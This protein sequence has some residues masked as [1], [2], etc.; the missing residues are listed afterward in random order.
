MPYNDKQNSSIKIG[1]FIFLLI[2]CSFAVFAGTEYHYGVNYTSVYSDDF[3]WSTSWASHNYNLSIDGGVSPTTLPNSPFNFA[4]VSGGT[5]AAGVNKS[6]AGTTYVSRLHIYDI[7]DSLIGNNYLSYDIYV[8][9]QTANGTDMDIVLVCGD[10]T[11]AIYNT[12]LITYLTSSNEIWARSSYSKF[13]TGAGDCRFSISRDVINNIELQWDLTSN[14]YSMYMNGINQ[15]NGLLGTPSANAC[16]QGF[17]LRF[18][19]GTN[20]KNFSGFIDNIRIATTLI[21][22]T[23]HDVNQPCANNLNCTTRYCNQGLCQFKLGNMACSNNGECQ[24]GLCSN[25]YC[26]SP[27]LSQNLGIF[28]DQF[29]GTDSTTSN[30][31]SV[32]VMILLAC[33]IGVTLGRLSPVIGALSGFSVFFIMG[34]LFAMMGWLSPWIIFGLILLLISFIVGA[35]VLSSRIS[36]GGGG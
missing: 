4:N 9:S 25:G 2:I 36:Q 19:G 22:S 21:N 8:S 29:F 16:V 33:V 28:K 11:P 14:S 32:I 26:T 23:T 18:D 17:D 7:F 31:I 13:A 15:C 12:I 5:Y 6:F 30:L 20:K 24:S 1:V 3:E 27:S 34:M 35:I 10:G